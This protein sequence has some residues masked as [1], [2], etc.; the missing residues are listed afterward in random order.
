MWLSPSCVQRNRLCSCSLFEKVF[1]FLFLRL[2]PPDAIAAVLS[3]HEERGELGGAQP[4]PMCPPS[5]PL[6]PFEA[7]FEAPLEAPLEASL[8][9]P[10]EAPLQA[11]PSS[12]P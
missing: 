1:Y 2:R 6:A 12:P 9:V 7:P 4:L 11:P 3:P 8:E 10:L 5:S